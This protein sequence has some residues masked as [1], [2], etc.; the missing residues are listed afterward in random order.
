MNS[1][2]WNKLVNYKIKFNY[3][4]WNAYKNKLNSLS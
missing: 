2:I 4:V 3:S 1:Y